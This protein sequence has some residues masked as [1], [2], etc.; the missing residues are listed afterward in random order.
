[1]CACVCACV[2]VCACDTM[3]AISC[4]SARVMQQQQHRR[5]GP[6]SSSSS[7]GAC[8]ARGC[9]GA[10]APAR[11][12]R[13]KDMIVRCTNPENTVEAAGE[14]TM[15]IARGMLM[16]IFIVRDTA[17]RP[18]CAESASGAACHRKKP[19]QESLSSFAQISP[20]TIPAQIPSHPCDTQSLL[21]RA[22]LI[23]AERPRIR[24]FCSV[25]PLMYRRT[26]SVAFSLEYEPVCPASHFTLS[27][28]D[29]AVI[30][31]QPSR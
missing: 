11:R 23:E 26:F 7:S 28:L 19:Q 16:E 4:S 20:A 2:C 8:G 25:G 13:S 14:W 10:V 29:I 27:T 17:G 6:S 22:W 9:R 30:P 15:H 18:L 21:D 24:M 31:E 3:A 12:Q 5:G 1:M